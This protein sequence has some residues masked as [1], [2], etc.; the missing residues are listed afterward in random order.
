MTDMPTRYLLIDYENVQPADLKGLAPKHLV[1][2]V[3]VGASQAKLQESL[4]TDLQRMSEFRVIRISGN[5]SNALD[6]HIAHHLGRIGAEDP[7]AAFVIVSKDKGFDPLLDHLKLRGV[8]VQ[9]VSCID[10]LVRENTVSETKRSSDA[11]ASRNELDLLIARLKNLKDARPKKIDGLQATIKNWIRGDDQKASNLIARLRER[12]IV[13]L[14]DKQISYD[15]L[16]A[17]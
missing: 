3:F 7:T 4:I 12:G 14:E 6:F 11:S 8:R 13:I 17:G 10:E 15:F 1:V 16:S 9:R 5:G 2:L